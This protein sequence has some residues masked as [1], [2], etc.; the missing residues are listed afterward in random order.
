L[1]EITSHTNLSSR[2]STAYVRNQAFYGTSHVGR[3]IGYVS[4]VLMESIND[5]GHYI[6]QINNCGKNNKWMIVSLHKTQSR[7]QKRPWHYFCCRSCTFFCFMAWIPFATII[8][9]TTRERERL[10]RYIEW[11]K[12]CVKRSKKKETKTIYISKANSDER[13]LDRNMIL[14]S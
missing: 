8:R 7:K 11:D 2:Q 5:D 3:T 12:S 9:I 14:S 10:L 4:I 1:T 6:I 13:N